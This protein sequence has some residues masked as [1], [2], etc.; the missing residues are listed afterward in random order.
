MVKTEK[1]RRISCEE[2]SIFKMKTTI[3][4]LTSAMKYMVPKSQIERFRIHCYNNNKK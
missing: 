2:I 3:P 1:K 4:E